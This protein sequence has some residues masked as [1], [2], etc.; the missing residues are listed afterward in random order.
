MKLYEEVGMEATE[1]HLLA[2]SWT[3]TYHLS[4]IAVNIDWFFLL[5][6]NQS[7]LKFAVMYLKASVKTKE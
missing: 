5:E 1:S 3:G 6:R 7:E 2:Q 4:T